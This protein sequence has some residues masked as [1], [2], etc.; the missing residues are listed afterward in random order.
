[1]AVCALELGCLCRCRAPAGAVAARCPSQW[2][3][4][5]SAAAG[6][7]GFQILFAVGVHTG[8]IKQDNCIGT[9]TFTSQSKNLSKFI[10]M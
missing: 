6:C 2:G 7:C 8:V 4:G 1:M 10:H 3:L 5:A 9:W